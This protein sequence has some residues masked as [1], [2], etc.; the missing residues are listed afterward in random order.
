MKP[1]KLVAFLCCG[2]AASMHAASVDPDAFQNMSF[3]KQDKIIA[4]AP[5][6]EKP[7]LMHLQRLSILK[8][9]YGGDKAFE[10]HQMERVIATR[11]FVNL[12]LLG[13]LQSQLWNTCD[14]RWEEVNQDL[15]K[16][17][18]SPART[19]RL[20]EGMS[21][22][23]KREKA[24]VFY[25]EYL[26]LLSQLAPSEEARSFQESIAPIID[27]YGKPSLPPD[28][29]LDDYKVRAEAFDKLFQGYIAKL[30]QL[31]RITTNQLKDELNALPE[32]NL[33]R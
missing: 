33:S 8:K 17:P 20:N 23:E 28:A 3:E 25:S 10:R 21:L 19:L 29:S 14:Y 5:E 27:K 1:I 2:I 15:P 32:E 6:A 4:S 11:G 18:P 22:Y 13:S 7:N 31:P 26:L 12:L 16:V 9:K 24:M 30:R